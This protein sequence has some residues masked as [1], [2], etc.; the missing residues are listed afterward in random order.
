LVA[1]DLDVVVRFAGVTEAEPI[2]G[3]AICNFLASTVTADQSGAVERVDTKAPA[4]RLAGAFFALFPADAAADRTAGFFAAFPAGA[5]DADRAAGRVPPIFSAV[6]FAPEADLAPVVDLAAA[7][8]DAVTAPDTAALTADAF[9]A[10]ERAGAFS[11]AERAGTFSAAE[12]AGTFRAADRA[13]AFDAAEPTDAFALAEP[14]G[15]FAE[16]AGLFAEPAG[17]LAEPT[18]A[19]AEPTDAF[20]VAERAGAFAP[21]EPAGACAAT[22]RAGAFALAE[23]TGACAATERADVAAADALRVVTERFV[24][25]AAAASDRASA[26]VAGVPAPLAGVLLVLLVGAFLA[27]GIGMSSLR[28]TAGSSPP[29]DCEVPAW[30]QEVGAGLA[31]LPGPAGVLGIPRRIA[32]LDRLEC[33]LC[34][35]S[36]AVGT[37][38]ILGRTHVIPSLDAVVA[39]APEVGAPTRPTVVHENTVHPESTK[40]YRFGQNVQNFHCGLS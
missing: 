3:S 39:E 10:A 14:A 22:E 13:G 38:P 1:V 16:P 40:R 36:A 11:A 12:P 19:L 4:V 21:A 24:G 20:R 29:G 30:T 34:V 6:A 18:D 32:L 25:L 28:M 15:T 17:A 37:E 33:P 7:G 8:L 27:A 23:P 35:V 31:F 26:R 2:A 9:A 5:A